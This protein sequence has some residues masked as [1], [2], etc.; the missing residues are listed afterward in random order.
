MTYDPIDTNDD[1]VVDADVDN[2]SVG[3]EKQTT[4]QQLVSRTRRTPAQ[5]AANLGDVIW[6]PGDSYG[7][8][9]G[10]NNALVSTSKFGQQSLKVETDNSNFIRIR[11]GDWSPPK[12]L[13]QQFFTMWI[14]TSTNIDYVNFKIWDDGLNTPTDIRGFPRN[15]TADKNG[16]V[17]VR[18]YSTPDFDTAMNEV[19]RILI[20]VALESTTDGEPI[21]LSPV[22][23]TPTASRGQVMFVFD[24][25]R[26]GT[27]EN[28]L[29]ILSREGP[30]VIPVAPD[31]VGDAGAMTLAQLKE[32]KEL[33][34]DII[35]H[36][37][38]DYSTKSEAEARDRWN[39]VKEWMLE[40]GFE[41]GADH[42]VWPQLNI[43]HYNVAQEYF[44]Q[45]FGFNTND[46]QYAI[47]PYLAKPDNIARL[48]DPS[49]ADAQ[50]AVD[51]AESTHGLAVIGIHEVGNDMSNADFSTLVDHVADADVDIVSMADVL[52][53]RRAGPA[54]SYDRSETRT[55]TFSGDGATTTFTV[56]HGLGL[57]TLPDSVTPTSADASGNFS[58]QN[59]SIGSF[60][61]EFAS[62]PASGSDNVTLRYT[63]SP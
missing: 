38:Q 62:A 17:K 8:N 6:M 31:I 25:A 45:M 32:A 2:Q 60:D 7:L 34:W 14:K 55:A 4:E 21:Y 28:A 12:D 54:D 50:G 44:E 24:D 39:Y 46:M 29:P 59:A 27:Y 40:N 53:Q 56:T 49:L 58:V 3:T 15:A 63:V 30:G 18:P 37:N 48:D 16:W 41:H 51:Y 43:G 13:F 11:I 33:G 35:A 22:W 47:S 5:Q 23:A 42:W 61:V 19:E 36:D 1:G 9:Q 20:D 52:D 10:K 57:R 26:D